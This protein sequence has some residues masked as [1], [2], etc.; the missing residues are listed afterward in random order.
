M[1]VDV[2]DEYKQGN[3]TDGIDPVAIYAH[4]GKEDA[5]NDDFQSDEP[6]YF[7]AE[8]YDHHHYKVEQNAHQHAITA[9]LG[10][11]GRIRGAYHQGA[12][13]DGHHGAQEAEMI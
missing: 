2:E 12:K 8:A 5:E 10:W 11:A 13:R 9:M 1:A 4:Q 3:D 7:P 6:G